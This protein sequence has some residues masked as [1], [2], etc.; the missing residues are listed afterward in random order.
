M[1]EIKQEDIHKLL[2]HFSRCL[3][4]AAEADSK[5]RQEIV[6]WEAHGSAL[7]I[8]YGNLW[9]VVKLLCKGR[10]YGQTNG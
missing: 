6:Q 2:E 7:R 10:C 4:K 5:V 3:Y 9:A 1:E 8:M